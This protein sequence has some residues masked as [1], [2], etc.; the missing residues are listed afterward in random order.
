MNDTRRPSTTRGP[1]NLESPD[2]TRGPIPTM[3]PRKGSRPPLPYR[4]ARTNSISILLIM[5]LIIAA[6]FM[7]SGGKAP[8]DP[9]GPGG[10]PTLPPYFSVKDYPRQNIIVP[11][12]T[13]PDEYRKNLQL[14][15]FTVDN[16]GENSVMVFLID[17]SG[18]MNDAGKW[19]N[20]KNALAYFFGN[21]GGKTVTGIYGFSK[22]VREAIPI[23]YYK[24]VK[25]QVATYIQKTKPS[26]WT[27]TRDGMKLVKEKLEEIITEKVY[28]GYKVNL[29]II[30]DGVPEVPPEQPRTCYVEADDPDTAP[31]KRCFAREQDPRV[32]TNLSRE[33]QQ[34][35]VDIYSINVYS[36]SYP[37]DR[38]MFP[39]L[40]AML[41]EIVTPPVDTHYYSSINGSNTKAL[42]DNIVKS[43]CSKNL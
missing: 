13:Q 1:E 14:K 32:P 39:Y 33:I 20:I 7:T 8:V 36:P 19:G 2:L 31:A 40:E 30:T 10:P 27:R 23:S 6:A 3:R 41:K 38:V 43:I 4:E 37:S 42:L 25:P 28:P 5:G 16:C 17:E 12:D 18:S 29:V 35:G 11:S 26:G 22:G 9:N 15:T 21:M 24:D 34:M